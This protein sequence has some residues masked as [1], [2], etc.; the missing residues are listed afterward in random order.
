M[1]FCVETADEGG[2]DTPD[3][4]DTPTVTTVTAA[5]QET[6]AGGEETATNAI[7][8]AVADAEGAVSMSGVEPG[9]WKLRYL[10][11]DADGAA[12][13]EYVTGEF[14]RKCGLVFAVR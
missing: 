5:V 11:T 13:L 12:L 9:Y 3:T 7:F 8:A 10:A 4:P 1:V 2:S 6:T 14:K